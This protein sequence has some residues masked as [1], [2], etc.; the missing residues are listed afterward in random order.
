MPLS[1]EQGSAYSV[2]NWSFHNERPWQCT[3]TNQMQ[4][5]KWIEMSVVF[6]QIIFS[7]YLLDD[8]IY[9]GAPVNLILNSATDCTRVDLSSVILRY[10]FEPI[11]GKPL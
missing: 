10:W 8:D 4:E 1:Y 9:F 7:N 6:K 11:Q 5:I 2:R 3:L